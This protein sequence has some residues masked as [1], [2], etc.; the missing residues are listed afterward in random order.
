MSERGSAERARPF[1]LASN[2][3]GV[4]GRET[5]ITASDR[6]DAARRK[7]RWRCGP[8]RR[9]RPATPYLSAA[10]HVIVAD[11]HLRTITHGHGEIEDPDGNEVWPLPGTRFGPEV[12]YHHTFAAP[13]LYKVWGQFRTA[14]DQ[15]V[16]ADFVVRVE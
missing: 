1:R 3:P 14:N 12:G 2:D 13:G 7:T 16:T 9:R 8:W 11:E 10:G 6:Q 15:V 5:S 4:V